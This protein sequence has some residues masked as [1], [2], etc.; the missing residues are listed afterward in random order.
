M[1]CDS[2]AHKYIDTQKNTITYED[3]YCRENIM[4]VLKPMMYLHDLLHKYT[5]LVTKFVISC[6]YKGKFIDRVPNPKLLFHTEY[7]NR[8]ML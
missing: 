8:S 2:Q 7:K 1:I 5:N 3:G 6:D 4:N